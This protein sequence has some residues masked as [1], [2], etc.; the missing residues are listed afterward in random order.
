V[1]K[2]TEENRALRRENEDLKKHNQMFKGRL[3]E[4]EKE[5]KDQ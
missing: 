4:E 1:T 5:N 3:V 2:I